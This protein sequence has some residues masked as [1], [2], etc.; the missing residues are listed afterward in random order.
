M[1]FISN[2]TTFP[3]NRSYLVIKVEIRLPKGR[4]CLHF[5]LIGI[6]QVL[7]KFGS[8]ILLAST[9]SN[10]L[11]GRGSEKAFNECLWGRP[12]AS[13]RRVLIFIHKSAVSLVAVR[14]ISLAQQTWGTWVG[15]DVSI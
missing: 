7:C 12:I 1:Q 6:H 11:L 2:H 3:T 13:A 9:R 15:D 5:L 4:Q 8:H 14:L 10:V